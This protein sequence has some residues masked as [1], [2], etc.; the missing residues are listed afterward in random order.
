M[1]NPNSMDKMKLIEAAAAPK[2]SK[3]QTNKLPADRQLGKNSDGYGI[4][5]DK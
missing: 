3:N 2:D 1:D 5:P 4:F